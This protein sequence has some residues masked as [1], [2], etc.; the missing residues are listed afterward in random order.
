MWAQAGLGA[1]MVLLLSLLQ[2]LQNVLFTRRALAD[3]L[4]CHRGL[5]EPS[6]ADGTG[7]KKAVAGG[8]RK[9]WGRVGE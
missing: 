2:F 9:C 1:E 6:G 5:Q 7:D 3:Q 8:A 4:A